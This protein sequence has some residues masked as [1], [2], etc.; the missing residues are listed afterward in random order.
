MNLTALTDLELH[1]ICGQCADDLATLHSHPHFITAH[2]D[3]IIHARTVLRY[4]K[5]E[6]W[7]RRPERSLAERIADPRYAQQN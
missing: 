2:C 3:D 7:A 5:E 6:L 1:I 4:A